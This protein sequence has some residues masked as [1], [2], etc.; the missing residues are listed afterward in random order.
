MTVQEPFLVLAMYFEGW[1]I[2]EEGSLIFYNYQSVNVDG[3]VLPE[4][5]R[6]AKMSFVFLVASQSRVFFWPL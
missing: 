1:R 6:V 4:Q 2:V 3:I 5:I